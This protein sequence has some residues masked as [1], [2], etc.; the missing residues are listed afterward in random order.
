MHQIRQTANGEK[1]D[2]G[3]VHLYF[4]YMTT[5]IGKWKLKQFTHSQRID[6]VTER[7]AKEGRLLLWGEI[8]S[9]RHYGK[10]RL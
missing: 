10:F 8:N 6:C 3:L 5:F 2:V 4:E 7:T 9:L 1:V